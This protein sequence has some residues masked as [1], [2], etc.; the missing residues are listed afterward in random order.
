MEGQNIVEIKTKGLK[1]DPRTKL[2]LLFLINGGIFG[3]SSWQVAIPLAS[4]P[5]VL[6]LFSKKFKG[7][8]IYFVIYGISAVVTFCA[9]DKFDGIVNLLLVMISGM[10][11][12]M[13]PGMMMGYFLVV[14]TTVSEFVAAMEQMHISPKIIIPMSVMFRFFPTVREEAS[15]IADAMKMRGLGFHIKTLFQN[16][17]EM[18]EYRVVPLLM[19]TV[20]IGD[21]LSAASLT[22]GLGAPIKRTNICKVGFHIQDGILSAVAVI[23][24]GVFILG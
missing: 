18:L 23:S 20:K 19:A 3:G 9:V 21:E 1:L 22:R 5:F 14:S 10:I 24:F 16:P 11:F 15:A 7:A 17:I 2:L 8:A 6:L 13:L 12:R 4:I